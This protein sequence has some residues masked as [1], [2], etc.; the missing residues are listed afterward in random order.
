[1]TSWK[2]KKR[3]TPKALLISFY[4]QCC[5]LKCAI[6]GFIPDFGWTIIVVCVVDTICPHFSPQIEHFFCKFFFFFFFVSKFDF[7][8]ILKISAKCFHSF[9]NRQLKIPFQTN[10]CD[11]KLSLFRCTN[12]IRIVLLVN[13]PW[14]WHYWGKKSRN[15]RNKKKQFSEDTNLFPANNYISIHSLSFSFSYTPSPRMFL[16]IFNSLSWNLFI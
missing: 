12:T 14:Y 3:N 8:R 16:T 2:K 10:S 11:Q 7:H 5:D 15:F 9:P 6:L 1:M 4:S 13:Y